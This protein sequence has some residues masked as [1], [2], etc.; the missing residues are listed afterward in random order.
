MTA[1][2]PVLYHTA[3]NLVNYPKKQLVA[4][5]H[6]WK[7]HSRP[8]LAL[9]NFI[10]FSAAYKAKMTGRFTLISSFTHKTNFQFIYSLAI[11]P[12]CVDARKSVPLPWASAYVM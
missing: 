6:V 8:I 4:V 1:L 9:I 2:A 7:N 10:P 3:G 11:N 12:V 5:Q